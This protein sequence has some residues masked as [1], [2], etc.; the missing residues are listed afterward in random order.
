MLVRA[1]MSGGGEVAINSCPDFCEAASVA[2]SGSKTFTF[3]KKPRL[4][5]VLNSYIYSNA[6]YRNYAVKDSGGVWKRWA[7]NGNVNNS[8]SESNLAALSGTITE[9][10]TSLTI[11]G[12]WSTYTS[13]FIVM[14]WY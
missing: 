11:S 6:I 3:T 14:A 4:V 1:N 7:I 8:Y 5:V 2:S 9:T 10:D 13:E 12:G